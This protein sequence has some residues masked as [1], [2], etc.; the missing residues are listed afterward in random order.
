MILTRITQYIKD[1]G[2]KSYVYH[3]WRDL[4]DEGGNK[5]GELRVLVLEDNTARVEYKCPEC[6]HEAYEEKP[7]K[8]PFNV[9]CQKC[10]CLI[11]VPKLRD[12]VK[13]K[14]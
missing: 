10:S 3:T 13:K 12:Q 14:K 2:V 6:G 4:E 5:K 11:R 9:K 7:W 8:R 1:H